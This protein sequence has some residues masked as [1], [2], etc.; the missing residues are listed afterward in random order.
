MEKIRLGKTG[1]MVSKVGF[2]GIPIQRVGEEEAMVVIGRC[3][4]LG[5]TF[6]DTAHMYSNSEERIGRA[7][8]GKRQSIVI[9]TKS[10]ARTREEIEKHLKLSLRRLGT[11]YIDLYQFHAVNTVR[12]LESIF[13]PGGAMEIFIRARDKAAYGLS[14]FHR[15]QFRWPWK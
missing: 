5:I 15:I 10:E 6:F 12:D 11:E 7:I 4:E 3:L 14:D 1:M 8:S 13:A 2:G 9:A